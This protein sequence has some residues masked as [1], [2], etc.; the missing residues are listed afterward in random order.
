MSFTPKV[1]LAGPI[2]GCSYGG[3]T[4]WRV[5][6]RE[7]L[8][9]YGIFG[10]SP[11]R[12]KD[13]LKDNENISADGKDYERLSVMSTA[14]GVMTRDRFDTTTA[15]VILLNL[16]GSTRVSIGSMVEVGWA[17]ANRVPIVCAIELA[18]NPHE[19]MMLSEAIGFRVASLEEAVKVVVNILKP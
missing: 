8:T 15:D 9:K 2:S 1:Y 11:M 10:F 14:R 5:G 17:D 4:E 12:A 13:Y 6:V 16:L 19:H 18:G 3:C 7:Q